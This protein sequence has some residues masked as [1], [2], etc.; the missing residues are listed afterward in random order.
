MQWCAW[1][2]Q[3]AMRSS[4]QAPLLKL[5]CYKLALQQLY[6]LHFPTSIDKS[7][8]MWHLHVLTITE[9]YASLIAKYF[10]N[11]KL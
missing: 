11:T 6:S 7:I 1:I 5:K 2:V 10:P 4:K 9:T 8:S 3:T